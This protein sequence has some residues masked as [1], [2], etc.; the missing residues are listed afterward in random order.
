MS[1]FSDFNRAES[2]RRGIDPAVSEAVWN[3]EGGLTEAARLGD[4]ETGNS[5]W[6]PQLH[7]G[8]SGYEHFGDTAGMGNSF[9][10]KTGWQPGDPKAWRDAMRYA[11]DRAKSSGWGAWYGAKAQGITGFRGID[12]NFGWPHRFA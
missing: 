4:F 1:V 12:T 2:I 7:Y 9:T 10:A 8:G 5:W 3:S 6:A 11:L